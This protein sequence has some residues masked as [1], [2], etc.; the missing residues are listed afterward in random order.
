MEKIK[1]NVPTIHSKKTLFGIKMNQNSNIWPYLLFIFGL[2]VLQGCEKDINKDIN[3]VTDIDGNV[4]HTVT[5]GT[6]VWM[7]ENLRTTRFND[8]SEIPNVIDVTEW[9]ALTTP[10]MCT[11]NN[12]TNLDDIRVYGRLYNWHA[13]N[14][15]KLA[16]LG[17][18]V[19]THAE[20]KILIDYLGGENAAGNKLK[21]AGATHWHGPNI[22]ATNESG[23]TALPGG[24]RESDGSFSAFG[25]AGFWWS[26]TKM[27]DSF[28]YTRYLLYGSED[29]SW[30]GVLKSEGLSVRCLKD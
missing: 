29:A 10:G 19:P 9:S 8:G 14:T 20:W 3:T 28:A 11:I 7:A 1:Y 23:F 27:D 25:N 26:S 12:T 24:W 2:M 6:Q 15:H 16:P 17:W 22:A 13:E 5:I 21:E 30:A 4:Y 18:H